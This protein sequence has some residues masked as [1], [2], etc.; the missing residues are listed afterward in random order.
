MK[1]DSVHF[2]KIVFSALVL[3]LSGSLVPSQTR[4]AEVYLL[5]G[6]FDIFSTG[7]NDIAK[8]LRARGV[9]AS[10]HGFGS[11]RSIANGIVKRASQ[12]KVSHPIIILGH[13]FGADA[14]SEFANYLGSRGISTGLVI[15]FDPTG[16]RV[17]TKGA[18]RVVNYRV[19]PGGRYVRGAGFNGS[20]SE[21]D[22]SRYG[23]NHMNMEQTGSIQK[24]A[25]SAVLSA[26]GR[27]R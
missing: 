27:R 25:I 26:T 5:R 15:G 1:T 13:S 2:M 4:A 7:M 22:A 8:D 21:I 19:P 10:S 17:F 12:K 14:A 23:V 20:L 9:N 16:T 11:W 6:G 18:K 3:L 24:L